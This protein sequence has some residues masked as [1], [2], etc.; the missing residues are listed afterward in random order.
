MIRKPRA[1]D[2]RISAMKPLTAKQRVE[3]A[4]LASLPD[5]KIDYSD[6]PRLKGGFWKRAVR[7]P[8]YRP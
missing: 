7:N 5:D 4:A 3:V 8:F 1:S 6:I 2:T